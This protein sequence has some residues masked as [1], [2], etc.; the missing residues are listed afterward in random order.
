[1]TLYLRYLQNILPMAGLD[2]KP[3]NRRL[4]VRAVREVLGMEKEDDGKILEAVKRVLASDKKQE[5]EQ[6]LVDRLMDY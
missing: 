5:F 4:L 2:N 6:K 3:E 1:M